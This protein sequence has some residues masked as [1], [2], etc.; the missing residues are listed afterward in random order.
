MKTPDGDVGLKTEMFYQFTAILLAA[1]LALLALDGTVFFELLLYCMMLATCLSGFVDGMSYGT[2]MLMCAETMLVGL[3][4]AH[5]LAIVWQ[6]WHPP[7]K[8]G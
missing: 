6:R 4:L 3:T 5:Y 7:E 1:W 2:A 8:Q